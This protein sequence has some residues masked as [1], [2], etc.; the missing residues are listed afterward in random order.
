MKRSEFIRR[1]RSMLVERRDSLAQSL[2]SELTNAWSAKPATDVRDFGDA[3]SDSE[4]R[5]LI[6][7]LANADARDLRQI[8]E[9]IAR[10]DVG[11]YG[12]CSTCHGNIPIIRLKALPY[13]TRCVRCQ[14]THDAGET[15][16][17]SSELPRDKGETEE[18]EISSGEAIEYR[19]SERADTFGITTFRPP[20]G[21]LGV[22]A[23]TD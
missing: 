5:E 13:A 20:R 18:V 10:V 12:V 23:M 3:A 17:W 11:K 7:E 22:V 2:R 9:A 6:A 19:H 15:I 8:N 16:E 1:V 14:T 21:S 4:F